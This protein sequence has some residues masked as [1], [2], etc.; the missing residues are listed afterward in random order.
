MIE[1]RN[2]SIKSRSENDPIFIVGPPRS[3]TSLLSA[4]IG[5]HSRIACGPETDLFRALPQCEAKA[6]SCGENWQEAAIERLEKIRYPD[7]KSIADHFGL[8]VSQLNSFLSDQD[9]SATSIYSA[10]PAA[11]ASAQGKARWAEKTPRHLFYVEEIR[12]L[13]PNAKFIRIIRDPRDSIPSVIKNIGLSTS[14]VGEF[15][16]WASVYAKSDPFFRKDAGSITVRYEDLVE[17]T[18]E[19]IS[20]ICEFLGEDFEPSMLDRG[21]ANHVRVASETWKSDI[22]KKITAENV[23]GWKS[24][25]DPDI[26]SVASL[27]CCEALEQLEYPDPIRPKRELQVFPLSENFGVANE[28][29]IIECAKKAYR[30]SPLNQPYPESISEALKLYPETL[31]GDLPLGKK[32][33][34]R[35]SRSIHA[36]VGIIMRFI[37]GR[38]VVVDPSINLGVG[39]LNRMIG[40]VALVF[41]RQK[42]FAK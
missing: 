24:K 18:A 5:S 13:F 36:T 35:I 7:G 12:R 29:H 31:L 41:G 22:D 38:P 16:R 11:F 23:Y 34:I 39:A 26:A 28:S 33:S 20:S 40:K 6:L 9:A 19:E 8:T 1:V 25:L 3:G 32:P 17:N 15:Y 4:I 30:Y 27:I 2:M 37:G 14:L 21:G 42:H 10:I